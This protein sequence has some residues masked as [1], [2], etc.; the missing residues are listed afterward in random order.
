[1]RLKSLSAFLIASLKF[2]IQM[3]L[4]FIELGLLMVIGTSYGKQFTNSENNKPMEIVILAL[5]WWAV[6]MTTNEENE[7]FT[8]KNNK[9]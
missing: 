2:A 7:Q 3:E 1:M 6:E 9:Q 4:C 8:P 5:L